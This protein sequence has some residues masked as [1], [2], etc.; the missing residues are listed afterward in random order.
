MALSISSLLFQT[1]FNY[2]CVFLKSLKRILKLFCFFFFNFHIILS[3][4]AWFLVQFLKLPF[5]SIYDL[6]PQF[7][8][9]RL[10]YIFKWKYFGFCFVLSPQK[11]IYAGNYFRKCSTVIYFIAS[12][13]WLCHIAPISLSLTANYL[14][15]KFLRINLKQSRYL[16][17]FNFMCFILHSKYLFHW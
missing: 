3:A 13:F 7:Q 8:G 11:A 4:I 15:L 17:H 14:I 10:E 9:L 5:I 2:T 12:L 6:S 16:I 1:Y